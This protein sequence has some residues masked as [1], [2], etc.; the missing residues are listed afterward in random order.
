MLWSGTL[1]DNRGVEAVLSSCSCSGMSAIPKY[2]ASKLW[3]RTVTIPSSP[4][5]KRRK[6]KVSFG[7]APGF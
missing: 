4:P 6:L 1:P 5:A 3:R 7:F 2:S